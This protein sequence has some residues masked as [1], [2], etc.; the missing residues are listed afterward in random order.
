MA[1]STLD[2]LLERT[3]VDVNGEKIGKVRQIYID[4]ESGSPTWVS[5]STG[6]F[7]SSSL[8]PL[9]GATYQADTEP[10]RVRVSKG[11]VKSAPRLDSA[12]RISRDA[13]IE[14]LAHYRIEPRQA[15]W[16]ISDLQQVHPDADAPMTDGRT[17]RSR[18]HVLDDEPTVDVPTRRAEGSDTEGV[19]SALD[20][21]NRHRRRPEDPQHHW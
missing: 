5:V 9:S 11:Q 2:S 3:V 8:V 19:R 18:T 13:E 21:M 1:Q 20:G 7:S 4:N 6:L 14:L 15:S 16:D 10:L 17:A 12:G